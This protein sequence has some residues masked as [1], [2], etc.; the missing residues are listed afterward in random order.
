MSGRTLSY[1][2]ASEPEGH[3][4]CSSIMSRQQHERDPGRELTVWISSQM[5]STLC[6]V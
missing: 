3:G 5:R 6:F 4:P 2:H 1:S